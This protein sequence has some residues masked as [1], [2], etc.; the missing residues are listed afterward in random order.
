MMMKKTTRS[1][2]MMTMSRIL[3]GISVPMMQGMLAEKKRIA[4]MLT[5]AMTNFKSMAPRPLDEDGRQEHFRKAQGRCLTGKDRLGHTEEFE[6]RNEEIAEIIK[7]G[8]KF[9]KEEAQ[10]P[11]GCNGR[12]DAKGH[13][14]TA[15]EVIRAELQ[16]RGLGRIRFKAELPSPLEAAS[17]FFRN[18][19]L[20]ARK[21]RVRNGRKGP[22]VGHNEEEGHGHGRKTRCNDGPA[23]IKSHDNTVPQ[24]T[25]E[26]ICSI[27]SG[28][29]L[30]CDVPR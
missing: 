22:D 7:D 17:L 4:E 20:F 19:G 15:H 24:P 11:N 8:C 1:N 26:Q 9:R 13:L 30:S 29:G 18:S 5:T 10:E 16:N 27:C 28:F 14:E 12:N 6:E 25:M 3:S 21:V 23:R 2:Q